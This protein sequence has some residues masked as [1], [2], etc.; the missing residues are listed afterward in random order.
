MKHGHIRHV[1]SLDTPA[2][3][4]VNNAPIETFA[5]GVG[6]RWYRALRKIVPILR[7]GYS[8]K[9]VRWLERNSQNYDAIIING[10]WNFAS[11]GTWIACRK[12]GAR[13]YIF[14]HGMLDPWSLKQY[15]LKGALKRIFWRLFEHRVVRD[16]VAVLYTCEQEKSLARVTYKP[17][18]ARE[19][20][21]GYGTVDLPADCERQIQAF[22]RDVPQTR[23]RKLILFLGR[24]HEKKGIDLLIRAFGKLAP[25]HPEFDLVI[26]GPGRQGLIQ[27]LSALSEAS[28]LSSRVHWT[29]MLTGEAKWG[30][31]RAASIFAL[32]SHQE[33]FGVAIAEALAAERP[34]LVS[35]KV[36]IWCEIE[37]A[38][39][40]V[41]V[42][43]D[44]PG[45]LAGL[46]KLCALSDEDHK[47]MGARGRLLFKEKFDME[48][49]SID[50]LRLLEQ[51]SITFRK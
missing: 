32:P 8:P 14:P 21:V 4:W 45:V 44:V 5:L 19:M 7:Y 40:G 43:D 12:A 39:A 13:Y 16:A 36:N 42:S 48:T 10:L 51:P 49:N 35:D 29:G 2:D 17:Y 15:P 31:F 50:L 3:N 6:A 24:I 20:V 37:E 46:K 26:A 28:G 1:A 30:A 18:R 38:R 34:V 25:L 27:D 23:G 33:N 47:L 9:L 22:Y 41:V 11:L